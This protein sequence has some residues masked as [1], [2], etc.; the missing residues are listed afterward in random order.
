MDVALQ[1]LHSYPNSIEQLKNLTNEIL[2]PMIN[3]LEDQQNEL[4]KARPKQPTVE[5]LLEQRKIKARQFREQFTLDRDGKR[6]TDE[7][8][9]SPD[10]VRKTPTPSPSGLTSGTINP[11]I[12]TIPPVPARNRHSITT[13][14][15]PLHS[16]SSTC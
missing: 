12:F 4:Q 11:S 14:K 3:H 1:S 9:G 10:V 15:Y 16:R 8:I 13:P 2:I 6:K 5:D 7:V